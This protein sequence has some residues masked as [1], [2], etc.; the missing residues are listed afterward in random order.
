MIRSSVFYSITFI[1]FLST[2][3][4][5]LA[6]LWLM[7]YDKQN[8]TNELNTKY[9][10]VARATLFH[11]NNFITNEE[12][13]EQV[14]DY[15]MTEISDSEKKEDI[16][17]NAQVIEEIQAKIGNSSILVHNKNHYLKITHNSTVLL[18]KDEDYQPYRYDV[19]RI[20]FASVFLILLAT[21]I[22]TIRKLKPLRK[23]KQEIDKF[24]RGDLEEVTCN[25]TGSDEIS[26]V[27]LAFYNAV[28]QIKALNQSRQLFLR[29]IM[30]ELKTPITKGRI[31]AEMVSQEKYKTRLITVFEKLETLIN[32][33][34]SIERITS[35]IGLSD[36]GEYRLVD[37]IDEAVDLAMVEAQSVQRNIS[38][39]ITLHVDFKLFSIALKNM[40]DNGIKYSKEKRVKVVADSNSIRFINLGDP[41]EQPFEHYLEPFTQGANS[42]KSL[43]L[44]LYI[45]ENIT[46]AHGL[47][48]AY[49][50]QNGYNVF[51]FEKLGVLI[52]NSVQ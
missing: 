19:I 6:F 23:L 49:R 21:Y 12:L 15:K 24:A 39:E 25:S 48:L 30:H 2:A 32:E 14:N 46:K 18:L 7:E 28:G 22:F 47:S 51:Y 16:I 29:N 35:G 50:H 36:V 37:L 44:G 41:L 43:G 38:E 20:I 1:F 3:S 4:I 10:I 8:Y 45:V 31:T 9:S 5:F 40:I 27:A 26:E 13:D 11:L 34:A 33:F 17:A 42:T 52:E